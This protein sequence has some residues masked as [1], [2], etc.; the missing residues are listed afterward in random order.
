M[1][2]PQVLAGFYSNFTK[3]DNN[4]FDKFFYRVQ[5]AIKIL[6]TQINEI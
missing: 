3:S 2:I 5:N 6:P 1:Q 4:N